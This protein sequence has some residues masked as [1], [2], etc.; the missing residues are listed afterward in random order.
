[1]S[2]APLSVSLQS[3]PP[4]ARLASPRV[5]CARR[6]RARI[7]ALALLGLTAAAGCADDEPADALRAADRAISPQGVAAIHLQRV[8]AAGKRF[9][10]L[11]A[12]TPESARGFEQLV[13]TRQV[14]LDLTA[15]AQRGSYDSTTIEVFPGTRRTWTEVSADDRGYVTGADGGFPPAGEAGAP[16]LSSRAVARWKELALM[17]PAYLVGY[18]LAHPDQVEARPD[19]ELDGQPC[20]V[21]AIAGVDG[22]PA[23]VRVWIDRA[24]G[25]PA[26]ADTIEDDP[27]YG[28]AA[29]EIRYADW[30]P[31][32]RSLAPFAIRERLAGA[33]IL[34]EQRAEITDDPEIAAGAFSV[35]DA[36]AGALDPELAELGR[37]A[38]AY[39]L[40][41]QEYGAAGYADAGRF[42]QPVVLA[43]APG[44]QIVLYGAAGY[45]TLAIELP[46][47]IFV[48]EAPLY[49]SV[50][51]AVIADIHRRWPGKPIQYL[52]STHFHYDHSGGVRTYAAEGA[53]LLVPIETAD[54]YR[55]MLDAPHTLVPDAFARG[56]RAVTLTA[57]GD[58]RTIREGGRVITVLD[59]RQSHSDGCLVVFVE[60]AGL[61]FTSDL[62]N[63]GFNSGPS[64][65]G[66]DRPFHDLY[67]RELVR[68][69]TE[70]GI[71][72]TTLTTFVGGHG[73][74]GTWEELRQFGGL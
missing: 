15:R 32:G 7:A 37:R 12:Y 51:A 67:A 44:A 64:P 3:A 1:M 41:T 57:V 10:H 71:T 4:R 19:A 70:L 21:V 66:P 22:W 27:V 55:A 18:G 24:T 5:S 30:R 63:P 6:P 60:D 25:L 16:M 36:L 56:P 29:L 31:A 58:R 8:V 61:L 26:A 48:A 40:R 2:L 65:T 35:P 49:E 14:D 11:E 52:A 50:S 28:D 23:P 43:A 74:T 20:Q 54:H 17:T 33:P 69:L 39:F 68:D 38:S 42:V 46:S 53:E 45:N 13:Y 9:D 47:A 62:Y 34:E 72:P 59:L 73:G